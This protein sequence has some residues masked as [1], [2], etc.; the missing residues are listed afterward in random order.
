MERVVQLLIKY[1]HDHGF[2][3]SLTC[4]ATA[5]ERFCRLGFTASICHLCH[6]GAVDL[7][8][9]VDLE[10]RDSS[11]GG[12]TRLRDIGLRYRTLK[13]LAEALGSS[14]YDIASRQSSSPSA[15]TVAAR[16]ALVDYIWAG[17]AQGFARR[18][19]QHRSPGYM[20]PILTAAA[21]RGNESLVRTL[22]QHHPYLPADTEALTSALN[23]AAF[24]NHTEVL[25]I[26]ASHCSEEAIVE[27][28]L[29]GLPSSGRYDNGSIFLPAL[30]RIASPEAVH[31][32]LL[33]QTMHDYRPERFEELFD[34]AD[35]RIKALAMYYFRFRQTQHRDWRRR[36]AFPP[37][38]PVVAKALLDIAAGD[39]RLE[40]VR[41]HLQGLRAGSRSSAQAET[42]P[43][44]D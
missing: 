42:S 30:G 20:G 13:E 34:L 32:S 4:P 7:H 36:L 39:G 18:F 6:A 29:C 9:A 40:E 17:V 25:E 43:C 2:L 22:I 5:I 38:D 37:S 24:A 3:E 15:A 33:L 10:F 44:V 1:S 16:R 12:L 14:S 11:G 35:A 31:A 41:A 26:L 8:T 19:T 28:F 21:S 27:A 23:A